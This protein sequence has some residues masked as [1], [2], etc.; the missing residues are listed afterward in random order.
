LW[1]QELQGRPY[2][3]SFFPPSTILVGIRASCLPS[4]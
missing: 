4:L 1:M 2:F 3:S